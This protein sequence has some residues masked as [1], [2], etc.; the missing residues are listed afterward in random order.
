MLCVTGV[1]L[2]DTTNFFSYFFNFAQFVYFCCLFAFFLNNETK[3]VLCVCVCVYFNVTQC[4]WLQMDVLELRVH[5]ESC[6][7]VV[8]TDFKFKPIKETSQPV[9]K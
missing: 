8:S 4:E 9:P 2:R 7:D 6:G 5:M 1:Y 3:H